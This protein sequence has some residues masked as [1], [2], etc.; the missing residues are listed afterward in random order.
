MG[1]GADGCGCRDGQQVPATAA[2]AVGGGDG[3]HLKPPVRRVRA[4]VFPCRV[5]MVG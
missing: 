4:G 3:G 1:L 5:F 2:E